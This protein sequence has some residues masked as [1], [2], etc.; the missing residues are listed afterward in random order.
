M[1]KK[2]DTLKNKKQSNFKILLK[3]HKSK[4][5]VRP[6]VN[7]SNSVTSCISKIFRFYNETYCIFTFFLFERLS[8]LNSTNPK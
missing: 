5:G 7:C 1:T 4:F 6:L 3:L 2:I 8:K